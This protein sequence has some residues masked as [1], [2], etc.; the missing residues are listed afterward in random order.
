LAISRARK[1]DLVA[2]YVE[3]LDVSEGITIVRTQGMQVTQVQTLRNVIREAGGQYVVA[4]NTL[5]TKAL[6]QKGWVVPEELLAGPT[7]VVFGKEDFPGV[8]KALL[9]HI[10]DVDLPQE[11]LLPIGGVLGGKSIFDAAGVEEVS[12][13]PTLPEIQ[14]QILGLLV[15]PAQQLVGVLQAA[16]SG[17]VNVLHAADSQVLNVLQAW[18]NKR[19]QEGAA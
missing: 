19:E 16:N 9:K 4:K 13:L 1:E 6:E 11:K 7:A 8:V 3:L 2:Q 18:L 14:A 5:I 10:K 15:Q 12:N 17:V